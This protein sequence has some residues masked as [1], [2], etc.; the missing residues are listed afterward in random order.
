VWSGA[1]PLAHGDDYWIVLDG[2]R[3]RTPARAFSPRAARAVARSSIRPRGRGPT[4]AGRACACATSCCSRCTSGRSRPRARSMRQ[5]STWVG[6]AT[7][8][9]QASELL[10][11]PRSRRARVGLRRRLP[12]VAQAAYGGPEG[13]Q[14]LVDAAHAAGIAVI[15]DVVPNHVGASGERRCARSARTSPGATRPLGARRST[16][17][18]PIPA[19]CVNG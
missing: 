6:S 8:G 18:T 4:G 9:S 1:A 13:V 12:V 14:R 2:R 7:S 3:C 11:L 10:R 17:D 16:N 15:L 5:S 19:R